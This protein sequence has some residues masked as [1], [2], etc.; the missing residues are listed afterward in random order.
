MKRFIVTIY[1]YYHRPYCYRSSGE[2][3]FLPLVVVTALSQQSLRLF[4][5]DNRIDIEI[6]INIYLNVGIFELKDA[7]YFLH[8]TLNTASV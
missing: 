8:C 1:H 7:F 5:E 4:S 2:F 6:Y 3:C